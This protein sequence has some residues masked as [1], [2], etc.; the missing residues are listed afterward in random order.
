[1]IKLNPDEKLV[2]K[3]KQ[4]IKDNNGYCPCS[5]LKTEDTICP[6]KKFRIDKECCCE[7]YIRSDYI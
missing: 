2:K 4:E 3:I 6:C 1:M 7:L 5:T